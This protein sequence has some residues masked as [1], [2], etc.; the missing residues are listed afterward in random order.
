MLTWVLCWF[1]YKV[2]ARPNGYLLLTIIFD[3]W[4]LIEFARAIGVR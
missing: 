4:I 1:C 3:T 2:K